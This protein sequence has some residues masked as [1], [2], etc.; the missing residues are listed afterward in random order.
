MSDRCGKAGCIGMPAEILAIFIGKT[1]SA[2]LDDLK[3]DK[4]PGGISGQWPEAQPAK[5]ISCE[6][7]FPAMEM[8]DTNPGEYLR[9]VHELSRISSLD[10]LFPDLPLLLFRPI[11][12]DCSGPNSARQSSILKQKNVLKI[13]MAGWLILTFRS[14]IFT[15]NL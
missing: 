13:L 12:Q 11:L 3:R 2:P 1:V 6:T 5:H 7:L 15:D 9:E 8:K 4:N 10:E 14:L